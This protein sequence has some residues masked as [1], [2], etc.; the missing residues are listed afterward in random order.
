MI[1][2]PRTAKMIA[3]VLTLTGTSFA[4]EFAVLN[5]GFRL[6]ADRHEIA[7]S[8]VRLYS[9]GGMTE[10][11]AVQIARF[12]AEDPIPQPPV[13]LASTPTPADL[14]TAAA[15][16][17]GLPAELVD[18]VVSAESAH[19]DEAISPKGAIGLM[20]LMP[21]T[22]HDYGA[23]PRDPKQNVEAGTRYLRDLLVKYDGSLS[24]ALAAYNAGPGA[25]DRYKGVP[26]YRETRAYVGRVMRKYQQKSAASKSAKRKPGEKIPDL[27]SPPK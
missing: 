10:L 4:G 6:H 22:A 14:V 3:V 24:H 12:E 23:D 20:Q 21:A 11:P 15:E 8:V 27:P 25:V 13:S 18:S 19:R 17:N 16:R 26:P 5:T 1:L 2:E 7:G 9:N